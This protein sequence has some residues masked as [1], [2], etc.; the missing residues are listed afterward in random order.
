MSGLNI[1]AISTADDSRASIKRQIIL[2]VLAVV[3][4]VVVGVPQVERLAANREVLK[5]YDFVQ[6]WS[7]GRQVLDGR[8]PYD[9]DELFALQR[10]MY[11][12]R[13]TVMMWN[14]PWALP[15]TLP[16][17]A[18]HWRL[19]QLLWFVMQL[20]AV[21]L[22]A[23]LLW[24]I[25]G[26][27]ER[28]RWVSWLVALTFAP[29][30]FLLLLGQISGLPLLGIA[31]FLYYIR[32][33]RPALAGC[34][35]VLTAIKPHLLPLFALALV[36]ES[37]HRRS[38][39]NAIATGAGILAALSLIPLLCNS[40]VWSQYFEAMRLPPSATLETMQEFEHPTMGYALRLLIPGQPFAAQFIPALVASLTFVVYWLVR[41]RSWQWEREMPLLVL[42]SLVSAVYG[43]WAFDLVILLVPIVQTTVRLTQSGTTKL[44]A[45]VGTSYLACNLL[46]LL[47]LADKGSQSNP[48][49]SL[50]VLA[51]W[52]GLNCRDLRRS[53]LA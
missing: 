39:R 20:T 24:R 1:V 22:S 26:G 4:I 42:V 46:L 19:A 2:V 21:L 6:Y 16:F 11:D 27:A 30:M 49:I 52:V 8:N 32:K 43:A 31:G 23:D 41:R 3:A 53:R 35:S 51:T 47:T 48:W 9:P 15:L 40:Q 36:L 13:K 25:Y 37:T 12:V 34:C 29:T 10:S 50:V 44:I 7:A 5:P 28:Y 18:L 45:V 17:A 14:P 38:I 33:D